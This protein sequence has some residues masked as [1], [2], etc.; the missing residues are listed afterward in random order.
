MFN[1]H[2]QLCLKLWMVNNVMDYDVSASIYSL[3]AVFPVR[4]WVVLQ[5]LWSMSPNCVL[6]RLWVQTPAVLIF[7]WT[8]CPIKASFHREWSNWAAE[9]ELFSSN[10]LPLLDPLGRAVENLLVQIG[11]DYERSRTLWEASGCSEMIQDAAVTCCHVPRSHV[12]G[13]GRART[14]CWRP[15]QDLQAS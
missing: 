10:L 6:L 4:T 3:N 1:R 8:F 9:P 15:G 13:G 14:S 11:R 12:P 2:I 7:L 5:L